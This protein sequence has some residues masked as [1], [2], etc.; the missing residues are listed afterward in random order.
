MTPRG[1]CI[2]L[3]GTLADSLPALRRAYARLAREC[4]GEP[5]EQ[6]FAALDGLAFRE[7]A[8]RLRRRLAPECASEEFATRYRGHVEAEH[9]AS[10]LAPGAREL[11]AAAQTSG[12]P[13]AVV[14]SGPEPLAERWLATHGLRREIA[15]LVGCEATP[16]GKPAADPYLLALSRIGRSAEESLAVEDSPAGA[17]AALGAKIPTCVVAPASRRAH[18][19]AACEF[20]SELSELMPR[21][22]DGS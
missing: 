18:F 15:A 19:P 1:L 21:L 14:T 2:D 12:V 8:E 16:R 11:L 7:V 5:S 3:D 6:E 17:E 13:V 9:A 10:P 22:R 20:V 4:G